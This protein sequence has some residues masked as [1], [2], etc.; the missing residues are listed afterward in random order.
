[1]NPSSDIAIPVTILAIAL[2]SGHFAFG[3]HGQGCFIVDEQGSVIQW[4]D[5]KSGLGSDVIIGFYADSAG[6]L[7]L[8]TENGINR[9]E[10]SSPLRLFG[11]VQGLTEGIDRIGYFDERLFAATKSGLFYLEETSTDLE[12]R[13][14]QFHKI[15]GIDYQTWDVAARNNFLLAGNFSGLYQVDR[16]LNSR[17]LLPGNI[18]ELYPSPSDS[19]RIYVGT[20]TGKLLTLNFTGGRWQINGPGTS[21]EGRIIRMVED[22][23]GSLWISTRY[24]G[25]YRLDWSSS[26]RT[27]SLDSG[28]DIKHLTTVDG[29][30]EI[31]YNIVSRVNDEVFFQ[32]KRACIGSILRIKDSYPTPCWHR[33]WAAV[34]QGLSI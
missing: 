32:P 12:K 31:R 3:T 18:S 6:G 29:L 4:L 1:M 26:N 27:R 16:A 9:V 8:A 34:F 25:V 28:Y 11:A 23:G 7:W 15:K 21:V 33:T 24:N 5:K 30:P 22:P 10:I 20:M 17:L 19:N 2:P 13:E 14:F